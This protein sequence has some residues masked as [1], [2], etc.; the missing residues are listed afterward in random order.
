MHA[1]ATERALHVTGAAA[2]TRLRQ[3]KRRLLLGFSYD[4][5]RLLVLPAVSFP[6]TLGF[7][8]I[9]VVRI[10]FIFSRDEKAR[11]RGL[12]REEPPGL[13]ISDLQCKNILASFSCGC[14][15]FEIKYFHI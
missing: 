7:S 2:P 14:K 3:I 13:E 4:F 8:L 6:P 1:A 12:A 15:V 11:M 5:V 10:R 9:L